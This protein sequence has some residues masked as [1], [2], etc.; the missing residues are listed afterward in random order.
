MSSFYAEKAGFDQ[1][2]HDVLSMS[3]SMRSMN[4][5]DLGDRS[6][7]SP[8]TEVDGKMRSSQRRRVPVAVGTQLHSWIS[9]SLT[10][11]FSVGGVEREK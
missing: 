9:T 5:P 11:L 4:Q 6:C 2:H 10:S 3:R 1:P 8:T 7:M